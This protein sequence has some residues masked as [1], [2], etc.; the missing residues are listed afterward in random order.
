[1]KII[2]KHDS[3]TPL[4][5]TVS[6]NLKRP[7][8]MMGKCSEA[9]LTVT[10][11]F[12][13][14]KASAFWGRI[15]KAFQ[16]NNGPN[17]ARIS[18]GGEEGALLLHK[19][20]GGTVYPKP[21]KKYLA[22]PASAAAKAA[23]W[24]S[25]GRTPPLRL[26]AWG[27]DGR[28][29]ALVEADVVRKVRGKWMKESPAFRRIWYWLVKFAHHLPDPEA[30]PPPEQVMAAVKSAALDYFA[31]VIKTGRNLKSG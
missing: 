28:P 12:Y 27:R 31:R 24:P 3:I 1:M 23:G 8:V 7:E 22:I 20:N 15:R 16:E 30:L 29:H 9:M 14:E 5:R 17:V 6:Q 10:D 21:P 18:I 26:G 25:H 2:V 13:G 11:E 4:L 19:V